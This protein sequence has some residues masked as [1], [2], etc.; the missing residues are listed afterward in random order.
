MFAHISVVCVTPNMMYPSASIHTDVGSKIPLDTLD[1]TSDA[2][3]MDK[4][5]MEWVRFSTSKN[6]KC[7]EALTVLC[8]NAIYTEGSLCH[9][10][11]MDYNYLLHPSASLDR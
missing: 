5:G 8:P 4:E 1:F 11:Q 6:G 3:E 10:F 7:N 9:W 2:S